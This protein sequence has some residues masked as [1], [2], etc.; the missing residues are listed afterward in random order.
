MVSLEAYLV[1][2]AVSIPT[3]R[4]ILKGAS[5]FTRNRSSPSSDINTFNSKKQGQPKSDLNNHGPF[6]RLD[7]YVYATGI[8][9]DGG[10]QPNEACGY[11]M[12]PLR[13]AGVRPHDEDGIR[14]DITVSVTFGGSIADRRIEGRPNNRSSA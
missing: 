14:K 7:E 2:L 6:Q 8:S 4:P 9:S 13:T 3:L 12:D 1:L 5:V 10:F 11:P